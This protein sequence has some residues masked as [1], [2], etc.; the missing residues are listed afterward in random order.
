V[1]AARRNDGVLPPEPDDDVL[2]S[3]EEEE[4]LLGGGMV[5]AV[6]GNGDGCGMIGACPVHAAEAAIADALL[7]VLRSALLPSQMCSLVDEEDDEEEE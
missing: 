5:V 7:S 3:K 6:N 2:L 4:E 1:D